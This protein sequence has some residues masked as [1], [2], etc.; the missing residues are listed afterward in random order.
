MRVNCLECGD[1]HDLDQISLAALEPAQWLGLTDAER[2][3]SEL[4]RDQC[5]VR[6]AQGASFYV[7][8]VIELPVLG[9]DSS[10]SLVVWVSLS[11]ASFS[12]MQEQWTGPDRVDTKPYFGWL[13]TAVPS[14]PDT[15][16]LKTMVYQRP[17]GMRPSIELEPT[18]HPLA[19][20]Q[21]DGVNTQTL[22]ELFHTAT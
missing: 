13:C 8:G 6:A 20:H 18:D 11:E 3:D 10:C 16:F 14:Y 12:E 2:S 22:L 1:E 9:S 21:R 4:T 15:M 7:A 5:I 19:V 17:V